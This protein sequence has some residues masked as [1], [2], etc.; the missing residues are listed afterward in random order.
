MNDIKEQLKKAKISITVIS[1][2]NGKNEV[3]LVSQ[4]NIENTVKI[5]EECMNAVVEHLPKINEHSKD[6]VGDKHV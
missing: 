2:K 5:L 1:H 6:S 3:E 4:M